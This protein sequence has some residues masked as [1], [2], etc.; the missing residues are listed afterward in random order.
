M[1]I[2][3][4]QIYM[5]NWPEYINLVPKRTEAISGPKAKNNQP[6]LKANTEKY[7]YKML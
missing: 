5:S 6:I 1:K 3:N 4:G 2:K 7:L